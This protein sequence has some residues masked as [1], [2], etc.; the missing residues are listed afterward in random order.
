M[1]LLPRRLAVITQI[2]IYTE[3]ACAPATLPSIAHFSQINYCVNVCQ[4]D[5]MM[6]GLNVMEGYNCSV[7]G[8][9]VYAIIY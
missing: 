3:L 5:N 1:L 2:R 4:L 6:T 9:C 7:L 8:L